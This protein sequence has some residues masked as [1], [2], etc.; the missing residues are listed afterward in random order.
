MFRHE[1]QS[2]PDDEEEEKD[3]FRRFTY[4]MTINHVGFTSS[5]W[6]CF[7]D[8]PVIPPTLFEC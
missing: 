5:V 1:I 4:T 7:R 8:I 6:W 2:P 3:D